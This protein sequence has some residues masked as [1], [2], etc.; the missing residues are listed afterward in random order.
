M[1]TEPSV[2]LPSRAT[3]GDQQHCSVLVAVYMVFLVTLI[4]FA[5]YVAGK[6][7]SLAFS[8][9]IVGGFGAVV[10]TSIVWVVARG[11]ARRGSGRR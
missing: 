5:R 10:A 9:A 11:G 2:R 4:A 3:R 8:A 7:A 6:G 1:K